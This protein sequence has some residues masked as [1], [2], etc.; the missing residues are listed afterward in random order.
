MPRQAA[1]LT[2]FIRFDRI[3]DHQSQIDQR[4]ILS[5]IQSDLRQT[6]EEISLTSRAEMKMLIEHLANCPT[7]LSISTRLSLDRMIESM[8]NIEQMSE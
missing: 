3:F 4:R 1:L 2:Q 8:M 5:E 7:D 6:E